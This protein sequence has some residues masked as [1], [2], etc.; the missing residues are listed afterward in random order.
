MKRPPRKIIDYDA[1]QIGKLQCDAPD[2]DYVSPTA[3]PWGPELIGMPCPKC[4]ANLLTER[5][6]RLTERFMR[7]VDFINRVFGP[8]FGRRV[9]PPGAPSMSVRFHDGETDIKIGRPG[10]GGAR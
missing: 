5:D 8:I 3:L 4:G 9:Q 2:C 1:S 6:Y 7:V 10:S